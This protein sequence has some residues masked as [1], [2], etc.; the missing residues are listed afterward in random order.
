EVEI[1]KIHEDDVAVFRRAAPSKIGCDALRSLHVGEA[2]TQDSKR[3]LDQFPLRAAEALEPFIPVRE[4]QAADLPVQQVEEWIETLLVTR[5]LELRPAELVQRLLEKPRTLA[6]IDDPL[7][8]RLRGNVILAQEQHLA[9]PE[10]D[11]LQVRRLGITLDELVQHAQRV[12]RL[13]GD[14]VC[15]GQLVEHRVVAAV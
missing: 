8:S 2:D 12:I 9:A 13:A 14:F 10:L 7:V 5:E 4:F 1:S 15:P 6:E 11:L 3:V